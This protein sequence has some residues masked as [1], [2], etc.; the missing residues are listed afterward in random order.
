MYLL[1]FSLSPVQSFI[2]QAR[3][4]RDFWAGSWLLSYLSGVGMVKALNEKKT[5]AVPD[6]TNNSMIKFIKDKSNYP[7]PKYG[8]LP[9]AFTVEVGDSE[10]EAVGLGR[11]IE[12][13]MRSEWIRIANVVQS[14][15]LQNLN[16]R[17]ERIWKDQIEKYWKVSWIVYQNDDNYSPPSLLKNWRDFDSVEITGSPCRMMD[18]LI[19]LS[20]YVR[21]KEKERQNS[22]WKGVRR[23]LRSYSL[24]ENEYLSSIGF[25]KRMFPSLTSKIF[26]KTQDGVFNNWPS[27]VDLA[28]LPWF[29]N[30]LKEDL[31]PIYNFLDMPNNEK[32][33]NEKYPLYNGEYFYQSKVEESIDLFSDDSNKKEIQKDYK[34]LLSTLEKKYGS[35]SSFYA[36]LIMDGDKIGELLRSMLEDGDGDSESSLKNMAR[37]S[38]ILGKFSQEVNNIIKEYDGELVYAGG[39]DVLALMPIDTVIKAAME[40]EKVYEE[41]MDELSSEDQKRTMSAGVVFANFTDPLRNSLFEAHYLIDSIAK[42]KNGRGSIAISTLK[43]QGRTSLY[44]TTWEWLNEI[45]LFDNDS[46]Q[47]NISKDKISSSFI[48]RFSEILIRLSNITTQKSGLLFELNIGE[49]EIKSLLNYELQTNREHQDNLEDEAS[50]IFKLLSHYY[51]D[52]DGKSTHSKKL[53]TD[54]LYLIRFL[55]QNIKGGKRND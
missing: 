38:H 31:E 24:N 48:Y 6:I 22:F 33:G 8:T 16:G 7:I 50:L 13:E 35:P 4:T 49:N 25:V 1:S 47:S 27:V 3:K 34:V 15:Y 55:S 9:N 54:G 44:Y 26:P 2:A 43:R 23:N 19:E 28:I 37:L 53:L 39:D 30:I 52:E 18:D 42:E 12:N 41:Q 29:R 21:A 40:I 17:Q 20:G 45:K 14:E 51:R 11:M 5:I 46:I 10:E 36:I 32:R